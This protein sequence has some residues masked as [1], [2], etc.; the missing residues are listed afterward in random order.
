MVKI[1]FFGAAEQVTGSC[2]LLD[3]GRETVLIDCGMFQ[4]SHDTFMKNYDA[5][6]FDPAKVDHMILSHAHADHSA[7]IPLLVSRG[8]KGKIHCH[9]ATAELAHLIVM[10]SAHIHEVEAGWRSRKNRRKG[11]GP[12]KPLYT[13]AEAETSLKRLARTHYHKTVELSRSISFTLHDAG[14]I[15]GSS[16]VEL[17]IRADHGPGTKIVFSGDLGRP[18]QPIIKDPEFLTSADYLVIE[19]TYG[20]RRHKPISDTKEELAEII[21]QAAKTDSN[22]IIP[23]FA[24]GRTQEMIFYIRELMDEGRIPKTYKN[25]YVDSP[26]A[27][28]ATGIYENAVRECYGEEALHYYDSHL[29]PLRFEGLHFVSSVD[30]SMLLN[31]TPGG[32]IIISASGMC[33]AGRILHHLRHNLWNENSHVIFV[34]YQAEGTKG[35]K[36]VDGAESVKIMREQISVKARIHTLNALSA[37]AD[38]D[39][40]VQ[41]ASHFKSPPKLTMVVHGEKDQAEGLKKRLKEELG[42]HATI[43]VMGETIALV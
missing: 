15:L 3:T 28:S 11:K 14:H 17:D 39:G 32:Q 18:G 4:G 22:I 13:T 12:V 25:I 19:S 24:V 26:M 38:T 43:P 23:S 6:G 20:A 37:H 8:Y 35:R 10:D 34:G 5:F 21:R 30:E 9:A 36:I 41:W 16:I 40:L 33:D 2:F 7:R 1:R 42:L 29:S 27:T 31:M